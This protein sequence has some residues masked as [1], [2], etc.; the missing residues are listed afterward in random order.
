M[1]DF[2]KKTVDTRREEFDLYETDLSFGWES[3]NRRLDGAQSQPVETSLYERWWN[4]TTR[5]AAAVALIGATSLA[6]LWTSNEGK[7][8]GQPTLSMVSPEMAETEEYY[9]MMISE[10]MD[11]IQSNGQWIDTG[12]IQDLKALDQAYT[13]LQADLTDNVDNEEVIHA[14]IINYKIKLEVL[15]R[16]LAQIKE[17]KNEADKNG[18]SL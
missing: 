2:L 8:D 16:I 17:A 3:V 4:G 5:L 12:V 15:D 7:V 10:K 11:E 9:A 6:L 1:T 18:S 13:E 14:M